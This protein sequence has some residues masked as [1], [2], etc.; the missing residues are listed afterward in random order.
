MQISV[1]NFLTLKLKQQQQQQ[2]KTNNMHENNKNYAIATESHHT[3]NLTITSD[4]D[5]LF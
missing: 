1:L 2:Q 3:F 5:R 4:D